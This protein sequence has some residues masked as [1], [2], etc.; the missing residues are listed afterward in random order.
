MAVSCVDMPN[1]R[2]AI[3]G[4]RSFA[5]PDVVRRYVASL[6][7]GAVVVSGGARGVDSIAE[8]AARARG[9]AVQVFPADWDGLGPKAG[10][11]RNAKIVKHADRLVAF[12]NGRSRGTLS[13]VLLAQ[14]ASL[15]IELYDE[16]GEVVSLETALAAAE[17]KG[18]RI[19]ES[20]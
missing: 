8:E 5:S 10:P 12:W 19:V 2:I 7:A 3:V 6:P 14:R 16:S 18:V 20:Q 9:L 13:G 4:S 15:P 11:I 1:L 17:V